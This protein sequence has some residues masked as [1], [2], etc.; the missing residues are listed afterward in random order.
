[1]DIENRNLK[2]EGDSLRA[3]RNSL[4]TEIGKLM[5]EKKLAEA[6]DIKKQVAEINTRLVTIE[7]K[8]SAMSNE[9]K[10]LMM[11]IPNIIDS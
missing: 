8:E 5:R 1:M 10:T 9:I 2:S 3:Q 11:S 4:S 6:E 7:E